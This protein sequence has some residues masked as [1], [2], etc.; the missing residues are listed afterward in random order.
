[1]N[2]RVLIAQLGAVLLVLSAAGSASASSITFDFN[3]LASNANNAAVQAYM[4]V[5]LGSAGS[6][7][8][9]G[10]QADNGYTGDDHVVGSGPWYNA[11]SV[12]LGNTEG[13]TKDGAPY[14]P[15]AT[16]RF[17]T[18]QPGTTYSM[19]MKFTGLTI[20][21]RELRLRDFPGRLL[22]KRQ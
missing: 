18:N 6:V 2:K 16:D 1:M 22:R 11:D 20:A 19:V 14:T 10:A 9:A 4:N 15:G 21:Q 7:T 5:K 17:I 8:V 12:T 13:A 3:S